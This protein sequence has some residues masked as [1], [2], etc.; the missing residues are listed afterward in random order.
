MS[1]EFDRLVAEFEKF[2]SKLTRIDEQMSGVADMQSELSELQATASN[3]DRSVTVVAGP[4]GA[5]MDIQ[6]TDKA[7]NQPPQAL[8]AAIKSTLQEAVA[9]AARKQ[10][11]IVDSH[12][13]GMGLNVTDQVIETQAQAFGIAPE[14]LRQRMADEMPARGGT[15]AEEE[16]HEDYSHQSVFDGD[17]D[18]GA[19][20]PP[21]SSGSG[22]ASAGDDF[23]K[24]LFNDEEGRR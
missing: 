21:P 18:S 6:L 8:A 9:E 4:G 13:G 2:Q 12:M 16:Y 20:T 10:A 22:S 11:G 7:M 15:P 24:N 17:G 5:V 14:E 23:L 1:A 3:A 19:A